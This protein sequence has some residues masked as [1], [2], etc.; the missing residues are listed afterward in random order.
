MKAYVDPGKIPFK[1]QAIASALKNS[2]G[3]PLIVGGPVRDVLL[4]RQPQDWDVAVDMDPQEILQVF[5]GA[6]TVGIELGRVSVGDVDVVSLRAEKDYRDKRHPS[7]VVFGVP[8]GKDLERRDFTI[9]AMAWDPFTGEIFDPFGGLEHLEHRALVCVGDAR[10]RFE[11]DP[12]RILRA[13]RFRTCLGLNF[14]AEL[15][16][17]IRERKGLLSRVSG[18]RVFAELRRILTSPAVCQGVTDLYEYGLSATILPEL[19]QAPHQVAAALSLCQPDLPAR[20]AVLLG[21]TETKPDDVQS[22]FNLPAS[23]TRQVEWL[24]LNCDPELILDKRSLPKG[25]SGLWK[26]PGGYTK[27]PGYMAR[28]I[29]YHWG[30]KQLERLMDVKRAIW[31]G[32]GNGGLPD[33]FLFLSAGY[34][35]ML[36]SD[37][38]DFMTLALDGNEI[39]ELLDVEQGQV[40]GEALEYLE[41]VVLQHPEMNRKQT[42]SQILLEWWSKRV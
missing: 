6:C 10:E 2:G 13:V 29:V 31:L 7:Q 33:D 42:L 23:L 27:D 12:L 37:C 21:I 18:E 35:L 28:R 8:L 20:L 11:E 16:E 4:G 19:D 32:R 39:M 24:V 30:V 41:D 22:R 26:Q 25:H 1:V 34:W 36:Q 15:V 14:D 40:V 9:N 3:T 17:A 38:Q 5:P